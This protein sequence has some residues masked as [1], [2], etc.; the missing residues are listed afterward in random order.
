[1]MK[2]S[3]VFGY[4]R[5]SSSTQNEDR[6]I[7]ALREMGVPENHIYVDKMTGKNF[8]RPEYKKLLKELDENSILYIKSID[9]LGSIPVI[10]K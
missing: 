1:M 4:A 10:Q 6:Q 7:L 2:K 3:K 8:N 9:R 5:V